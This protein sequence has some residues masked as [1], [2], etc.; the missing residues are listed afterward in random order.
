MAGLG[1]VS[2]AGHDLI[3]SCSSMSYSEAEDI[4]M[5][6]PKHDFHR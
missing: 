4:D 6:L 5:D 1:G 2:G 3:S